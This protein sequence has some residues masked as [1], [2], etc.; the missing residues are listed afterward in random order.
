MDQNYKADMAVILMKIKIS[1][2]WHHCSRIFKTNLKTHI[3]PLL[4]RPQG[5]NI[6]FLE[7]TTCK[8]IS[9]SILKS[10]PNSLITWAC[11]LS[12]LISIMLCQSILKTVSNLTF[13][14]LYLVKITHYIRIIGNLTRSR[15]F[16]IL[17]Q[18]HLT[19]LTHVQC[20]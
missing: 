18:K 9:V 11:L 7:N 1:A 8:K 4:N 19:H 17:F 16:L 6:P 3:S 13:I 2:R 5:Y 10:I 15:H 12:Y 20:A 14:S